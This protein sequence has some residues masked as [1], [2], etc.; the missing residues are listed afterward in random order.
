[1]VDLAKSLQGHEDRDDEVGI[2][3]PIDVHGGI[4]RELQ[5][6]T[7]SIDFPIESLS[8][9]KILPPTRTPPKN[10][11]KISNEIKTVCL[12]CT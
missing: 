11:K 9:E 3:N 6:E 5:K 2:S 10:S 12:R 4:S 7:H 1:M 8:N